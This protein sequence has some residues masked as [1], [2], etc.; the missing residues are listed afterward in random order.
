[1]PV[2]YAKRIRETS[3]GSILQ[4]K[5][6]VGIYFGRESCPHCGPFLRSLVA[7][8]RRRR[9]A[10]IVFVSRGASEADTMRYFYKMP[11]WT[12]MP[13]VAV[14]GTLGKAL[15]AR[16][17]VTT[18]PTLVLLHSNGQVICTDARNHLAGDP[19]GLE[20]LASPS[21][22][23]AQKPSGQFCNG[24]LKKSKAGRGPSAEPT[25]NPSAP[26]CRIG[27]FKRPAPTPAAPTQWWSAPKFH[28]RQA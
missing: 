25:S 8:L 20:G 1:M 18:I 3:P 11:R 6:V 24:H 21:R 19:D 23:S 5:S 22:R 28:K 13:H 16:F 12:A 27:S 14:A 9:E 10:T 2:N 4:S 15:V 26:K 17:G 7:L